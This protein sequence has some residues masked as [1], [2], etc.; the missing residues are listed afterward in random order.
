MDASTNATNR[1]FVKLPNF[2][3][4]FVF[5]QEF[6]FPTKSD[7]SKIEI[8]LQSLLCSQNITF[9]NLDSIRPF[10]KMIS[11]RM[12]LLPTNILTSLMELNVNG[13]KIPIKVANPGINLGEME[14]IRALISTQYKA[15]EAEMIK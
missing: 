4:N 14:K 13:R 6:P 8:L 3:I 9:S 2:E 12:D 7:S 1:E 5:T 11:E 15:K 10:F